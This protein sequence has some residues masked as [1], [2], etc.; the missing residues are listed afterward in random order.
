MFAVAWGSYYRSRSW[1]QTGWERSTSIPAEPDVLTIDSA[2]QA[3][4]VHLSGAQVIANRLEGGSWQSR[5]VS[6]TGDTQAKAVQ[7]LATTRGDTA[8]VYFTSGI[9]LLQVSHKPAVPVDPGSG[10]PVTSYQGIS[11]KS[12]GV[13]SYTITL[14]PSEPAITWFRLAGQGAVVTGGVNVSTWQTYSAEVVI[15]LDKK[16]SATFEYYSEDVDGN[17]EAVNTEVLQ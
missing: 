8:A 17:I 16:G 1:S 14:A 6:E 5:Q 9:T 10:T 7:H 11:G 15:Q 12:K 13:T 2:G 3:I 4:S